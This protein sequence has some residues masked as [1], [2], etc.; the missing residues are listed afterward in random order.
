MMIYDEIAGI[1]LPVVWTLMSSKTEICYKQ[2]FSCLFSINPNIDIYKA[3]VD[4]E[5]A[6]F[7]GVSFW[8]P[9]AI[10]IGCF[11]HFM[12]ALRKKMG[13]LHILKGEIK[14]AVEAFQ[15]IIV[16]P[17]DEL[18][19][20]GIDFIMSIIIDYLEAQIENYVMP[21]KSKKKWVKFWV[22]FRK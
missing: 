8:F 4:F 5:P 11:F 21:K 6:L 12:Q 2:A 17:P 10:T 19:E 15:Y 20:K 18:D 7:K 16:L 22:Y 3:G 13:E 9:D 1:Y 14:A